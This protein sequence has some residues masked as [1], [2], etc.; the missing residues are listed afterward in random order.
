MT[1]D[2]DSIKPIYIEKLFKSKN[3]GLARI[4]P[5]FVYSW[6][7]RIICQD[8]INDFISKYGK[9][10][11]LDFADAIL[12]Y[13]D[14]TFE[15]TGSQNLPTPRGR[16]IF[17]SNHPL[18]GPDGIMLISFLGQQ[19]PNLK[20]PVNDLLMNLKNLNNIFLPVN[21]HGGMG[22]EAARAIEDAYA[23]KDQIIMFPAGMVS[24]KS[25]GVV[26]DLEWQKSF[27]SK[28]IKHQRDIVPILV[29]GRNSDFF[30]NLANFRKKIGLKIN[31]EM[32]FLPRETFRKRG[33]AFSMKIGKPIKWETLDKSKTTQEWAESIKDIVYQL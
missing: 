22:R 30:Y 27:I 7:K 8:Q 20:F 2:C 21:K 6:L 33:Q 19:Y 1:S 26:K 25:K 18:G 14:I 3:P 23:S 12:E 10:K 16:Y 32:L 5:G 11:G 28:A 24:R 13:L 15:V 4:I 29:E 9:R 17:V 31:L